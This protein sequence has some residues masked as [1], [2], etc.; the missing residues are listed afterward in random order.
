MSSA[1]TGGYETAKIYLLD[2]QY[3][4][5]D[6]VEVLFNPTEYSVDKSVQ[7]GELSLPGMDTPVTQFVSGK[8]ETLS[9]DLL[10]D[11]HDAAEDVRTHVEKFDRL[12]SVDGDRHAP[13]L[14]RFVWG[15]LTFTSVVEQLK[16]RFTLFM[17]DGQPVRA[18]LSVT[19][20]HHE[21]PKQQT[22][23]EPRSSPDRAKLRRVTEGQS[24]WALAAEEYGDP[25]RWRVIAEANGVTNPRRLEPGRELLVPPLEGEP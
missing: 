18:E 7:Y 3:R 14:C 15:G 21:T 1:P 19:F 17:P 9:M 8:A 20:K 4:E 23:R 2:R 6:E 16:K 22:D 25:G 5:I 10:V 11:T 24:L 13:P 12:V